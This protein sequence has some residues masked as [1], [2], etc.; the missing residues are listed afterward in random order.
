MRP[1]IAVIDYGMGNLRSVSKALESV[2]AAAVVTSSA[3]TVR[4]A[5]AVVLPGVGSFGE[6]VRR[7]RKEKLWD[8]LQETL[9][10][11]K[12]FLGICLGLQL[13][14]ERS[15]ESPGTKGLGFLKGSVVRFNNRRGNLKVPHIGWNRIKLRRGNSSP[16]LQGLRSER[17]FYFV[18]SYFPAP[19]EKRWVA[20][21]T[22][23]GKEFCSAVAGP[24][25]MASQFHPEKSGTEGLRVLRHFVNRVQTLC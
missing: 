8:V 19:R 2:G 1:S 13:L 15:E 23:Y 24:A 12:P 14:F 11:G 16:W 21:T 6:A 17:H 5:Q 9:R 10:D 18:H 3:N 20:A 22:S 7:L 4:G 25:F